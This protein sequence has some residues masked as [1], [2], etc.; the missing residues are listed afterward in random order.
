MKVALFS[1]LH[2]NICGLRAVL[3]CLDE[4]GGVDTLV[5]AGDLLGG[6][7]GAEDLLDLLLERKALLLRGNQEELTVDLRGTLHHV[8]ERWRSYTHDMDEW[9]QSNLSRSYLSLLATLPLLATIELAPGRRMLACHATPR[10]CWDN[11][12]SPYVPTTVLRQAYG[13]ADAEMI[14]YGHWHGHHLLMLDDKMLVNVSSVGLRKDGLS[15]FTLVEH[16]HDRWVVQQ[17]QVPYDTKEEARLMVKREVPL[18]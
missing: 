5:A 8:P 14:C 1:D 11:V 18:P 12:C 3:A 17:H 16:I 4:I 9:L 15:A 6:G 13:G 7:P 2:G 10:S